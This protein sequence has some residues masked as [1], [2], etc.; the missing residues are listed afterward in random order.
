M[1]NGEC[2]FIRCLSLSRL[3][4]VL[5]FL[6]VCLISAT[7]QETRAV[8]RVA[9]ETIAR[10]DRLTLGDLAEVQAMNETFRERLR[11]VELGY[12]PNVGQVREIQRERILLSL[13][14]AGIPAERIS[15]DAP[16]VVRVRRLA[17]VIDQA[18]AREAVE[19]VALAELIAGG[20]TARLVRLDLPPLI[21]APSG[22]VEVRASTGAV[23]DL[24]APFTVFIDV[25]VDGRLASRF[26]A[27]ALLEAHAPIVVAAKDVAAG[28]GA[29]KEDFVI[30]NRRL[31]KPLSAYLR[32]LNLARGMTLKRSVARDEALTTDALVADIIIRSGDTVRI[33]A[34]SS[35]NGWQIIVAGEARGAGRINERIPV[36]NKISGALVQARVIDEGLVQ[37]EF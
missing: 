21:E 7:A 5:Q 24:F 32:D 2:C 4:L 8:V 16:A 19:R 12:A 26:A 15:F 25:R 17:Q 36:R 35:G 33:V 18:L 29:S 13:A 1:E 3:I 22:S 31:E 14:A 20:A 10:S 11:S 27:T 37:V 23:R 30:A 9:A 28:N 6:L 34:Q